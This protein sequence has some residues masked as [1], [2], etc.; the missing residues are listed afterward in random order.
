MAYFS[1]EPASERRNLTGKNRVWDFFPLSNKPHPAN[2]RQPLQPRRETRPTPTKTASGIPYWPS[3]DPIEEDGGMNLY[4]FVG[5]DGVNWLDILG[6]HVG[7]LPEIIGS[8]KITKG[9]A[10]ECFEAFKKHIKDTIGERIYDELDKKIDW[11][12]MITVS[13][14]SGKTYVKDG[15]EIQKGPEK[16]LLIEWDCCLAGKFDGGSISPATSLAHEIGHA[17]EALRDP[18]S[19]VKRLQEKDDKYGNAEE[20]RV[21]TEVEIPIAE[22][23]GEG[24]RTKIKASGLPVSKANSIERDPNR[25]DYPSGRGS[26]PMQ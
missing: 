17:I 13:K 2:R 14:G 15:W 10:D 25:A 26:A 19:M 18:D 21:I 8:Y 3:R 6:Q 23:R 5:N 12:V 9:E 20:K 7:V 1:T 11:N 16:V 22:K 24:K 4:G